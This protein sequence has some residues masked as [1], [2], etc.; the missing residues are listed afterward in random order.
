MEILI[1]ESKVGTLKLS[2]LVIKKFIYMLL[3]NDNYQL[4]LED[5]EVLMLETNDITAINNN[6][7]MRIKLIVN[8]NEDLVNLKN[9]INNLILRRTESA[10]NLFL[11]NIHIIFIAQTKEVE[12]NNARTKEDNPAS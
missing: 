12:I 9:K 7:V 8:P 4:T 5:V 2:S 3:I 6:I 1:E 10:L 11:L